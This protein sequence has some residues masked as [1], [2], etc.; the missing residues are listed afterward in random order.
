MLGPDDLM[1]HLRIARKE[2][3][4]TAYWLQLL[5]SE[6]STCIVLLLQ[7]AEELR[8]ILSAIINKIASQKTP[9]KN[10]SQAIPSDS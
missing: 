10:A 6:D 4:E 3:K 1:M 8:R 9:L 2:A 7:E 5:A